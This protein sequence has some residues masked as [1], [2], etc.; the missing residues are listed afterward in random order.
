MK[1]LAMLLMLFGALYV[2]Q[3]EGHYRDIG[4][5]LVYCPNGCWDADQTSYCSDLGC[6]KDIVNKYGVKYLKVYKIEYSDTKATVKRMN[7]V[8]AYDFVE[9]RD[10]A[11]KREMVEVLKKGER[12]EHPEID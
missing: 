11:I 5:T 3:Y 1:R 2:V 4:N 12:N 10:D 9:V 8:A 6:V 7:P